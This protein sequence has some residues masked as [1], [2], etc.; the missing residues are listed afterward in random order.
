MSHIRRLIA[1]VVA[2]KWYALALFAALIAIVFF[3]VRGGSEETDVA[4]SH[5]G[6][7]IIAVADY[8]QGARGVAV[9][10]ANGNSYVIRSEAAGRVTRTGNAGSVVQGALIAQLENSSQRA[11]LL[12]AEGTYEAALASSGGSATSQESALQDGI[13]TWTTATVKAA[14]TLRTSIDGYFGNVRGTQGTSGFRMEAFGTAQALNDA[15][16]SIENTV[17]EKWETERVSSANIIVKLQQLDADLTTIA[18]L[19]DRIAALIP[20]QEITDVYSESDRS[21]DS[22]AL[23]AARAAITTQQE[24]VDAARLAITKASGSGDASAQAQVKQALGTL[25]AA[26]SNYEKTIVRAPFAGTI[27]S[28]NVTVGDVISTGSD[29]A[30]IVPKSGAETTR[31]FALPL[32]AVKYTPAGAFV[33]TVNNEGTLESRAVE[34]GLVTAESI[35]VTGLN[36]DEQIVKDVRGLKN[37]QVVEVA[38]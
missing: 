14:E 1:F 12:Q 28:V 38:A 11:A 8:S 16:N 22:A 36:G 23:A 25:E 4:A 21:A 15:R 29:I 3:F 18:S 5:R 37:G 17:L 9:P 35:V 10:T 6:V 34:T 13:R 32:S 26:R 24:N 7:E 30:I 2:H 20:R 27:T 31:S 33:F 19:I